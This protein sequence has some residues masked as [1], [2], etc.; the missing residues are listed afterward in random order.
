MTLCLEPELAKKM[1]LCAVEQGKTRLE[2]TNEALS[3]SLEQSAS[4]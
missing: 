2:I 4:G 3:A 1:A